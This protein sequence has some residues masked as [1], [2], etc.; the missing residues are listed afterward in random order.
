MEMKD[1]VTTFTLTMG[2]VVIADATKATM[3]LFWWSVS[4]CLQQDTTT[5]FVRMGTLSDHWL[6][7]RSPKFPFEACV[8]LALWWNCERFDGW[9]PS[10]RGKMVSQLS[11]LLS[12]LSL[13]IEHID[14]AHATRGSM[15][16]FWWSFSLHLRTV[17][18]EESVLQWI[19]ISNLG[20]RR[21]S[22]IQWLLIW[23]YF[24]D[25][26]VDQIGWLQT[27][28]LGVLLAYCWS[29]VEWCPIW[30]VS[31]LICHPICINLTFL[32]V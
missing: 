6:F 26:W 22:E 7:F 2:S 19:Q 13:K 27:F 20:E 25:S 11:L 16:L 28:N 4:H 17:L 24:Q 31:F 12:G 14:I 29:D 10:W 32:R 21:K 9:L 3:L 15:L 23:L 30:V 1:G 5:M 8:H 18:L